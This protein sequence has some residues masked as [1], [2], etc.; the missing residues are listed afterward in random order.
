MGV[1][2]I[3]DGETINL[4]IEMTGTIDMMTAEEVMTD[5][6]M[7]VAVQGTEILTVI[8]MVLEVEGKRGMVVKI[9]AQSPYLPSL[10]YL[11]QKMKTS[12]HRP[13]PRSPSSTS[14]NTDDDIPLA[15]QIS[16]TLTAQRT[17]RQQVRD[18]RD[19]C[20]QQSTTTGDSA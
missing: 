7:V 17:I 11:T 14:T 4:V 8:I 1:G 18:E 10:P 3:A 6:V 13:Y 12:G 19:Q 20:R 9:D 5:E 16:T 15:Q 2:G